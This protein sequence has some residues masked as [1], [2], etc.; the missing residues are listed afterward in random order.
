M[1]NVSLSQATG[2]W[3]LLTAIIGLCV[4]SFINVVAQRLP[5]IMLSEWQADVADFIHT[6]PDSQHLSHQDDRQAMPVSTAKQTI[7]SLI[8]TDNQPRLTLSHPRS[9]CP[10][11]THPIAW[12]DNLPVLSYLLLGAKCRHCQTAISPLYPA[13]ELVT[14]LLSVFVI[15]VFGVSMMGGL[16][17]LFTWL[18]ISLS[19]IDW[20]VKLLPDRL[21]LPLAL[22]GLSANAFGLFTTPT[23]AMLGLVAGFMSLWLIATVFKIITAKDGMG[24][25]DAKLLAAIGAWLGISALPLVVFI[26]AV[27][28]VIVGLFLQLKTGKASAFAFG[29]YLAIAAFILLISGDKLWAWYLGAFF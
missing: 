11:C 21:V 27:L 17:L 4:G 23:S 19:A 13:T 22:I 25:G 10:H 5:L 14:A 9:H 3:L 26:A 20:R 12:Y 18:L 8:N 1:L 24:L 16:A 28:G 29:P 15:A 2:I 6:L 7:F